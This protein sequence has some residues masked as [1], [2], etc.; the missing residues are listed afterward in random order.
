MA[1]AAV[2][3]AAVSTGCGPGIGGTGTG[4]PVGD[5]ASFDAVA[6]SVCSAPFAA[7]LACGGSSPVPT[8]S[9]TPAPPPAAN[10]GP[11]P[12]PSPAPSTTPSPT[13]AIGTTRKVYADAA[14][15]TALSIVFDGNQVTL[16]ARCLRLAFVGTWG[17]DPQGAARFFGTAQVLAS[18]TAQAAQLVV[19]PT[20]GATGGATGLTAQ[21]LARDGTVLIGPVV[22][23]ATAALPPAP[24]RCP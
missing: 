13:D 15:G 17:L 19:T 6:V 11:S 3:L 16:D 23:V 1:M 18:G 2:F 7:Q 12:A 22:L 24:E 8:P 20:A 14:T 10:P 5:L 9:P 21:L 4:A